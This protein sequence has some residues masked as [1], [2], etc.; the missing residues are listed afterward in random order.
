MKSNCECVSEINKELKAKT[1]AADACL[2]FNIMSGCVLLHYYYTPEGKKTE[3]A[4]C[5]TPSYCP[6]CGKAYIE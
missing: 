3:K 6:F 2:L 4:G 1:R 5:I